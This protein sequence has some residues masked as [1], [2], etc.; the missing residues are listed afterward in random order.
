[1]NAVSESGSILVLTILSSI[2]F[3]S[4][5]MSGRVMDVA[6]WVVGKLCVVSSSLWVSLV[7]DAEFS[8]CIA[9]GLEGI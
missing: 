3:G 5:G 6:C 1:L 4:V 2:S 7:Y 8:E 9:E